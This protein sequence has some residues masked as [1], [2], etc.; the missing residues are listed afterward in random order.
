ML[1]HQTVAETV[2]DQLAEWGLDAVFGV[3]GDA[4]I[5]LLDA[6]GAQDRVRFYPARREDAAAFMASAYGKL[7]GR[8]GVCI[9]TSGPGAANLIN[10][11]AD[12]AQDRIPLLVITGQVESWY[13]GTNYK[14]Y[15]D[16]LGLYRPF[17]TYTT[18][19]ANPQ[20]TVEV[21][22]H[23]IKAAVTRRMVSHVSIPKDLFAMAAPAAI[24]PPEP[25]LLTHPISP[26]EVIDGVL[27]ILNQARQPVILAG[28]GTKGY[29]AEL[30]A[31]AEQW[32]AGI[33]HTMPA[34]GVVPYAHPLAL[35][36]LGLAG[37][38]PAANAVARADLCLV[39][40]ATW[41]PPDHAPR[42]L[43]VV[44]IDVDPANIGVQT[45]VHYGIVG[46]VGRILPILTAQIADNPRTDWR[47]TIETLRR[48]WQE[49]MAGETG[50]DRGPIS[51]QFLVRTLQ[52]AVDPYAVIALDVGD[53]FVWFAR[54]YEARY[55]DVLI[56]GRWRS[57]GFGLPA[58]I[59]ARLRHPERQ[60][61][62]FT[63]DGGFGMV[64]AELATVV[65][66]YLPITIVVVN[67]QVLAMELN[68]M[69]VGNYRPV[70]VNLHNPNFADFARSV[71]CLGWRVEHPADLAPALREALSANQP[72]LV[73]VLTANVVAPGTKV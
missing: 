9:A 53:H 50:C 40:G 38:D 13:I 2:V 33:V 26:P 18:M 52:D 61:V 24:R 67:N 23:A 62:V 17:T 21:L 51:P 63:G 41:W 3:A 11:V 59:T 60:V 4:I 72:A 29:T 28:R 32:G 12:A 56:S 54:V 69:V 48:E 43:P 14:Q 64:M 34:T 27:P 45:P 7:T 31:F 22:T 30:T 71:G 36:S 49:R 66:L 47:H 1:K 55:E 46:D 57:M 16:H 8:P 44:Q 15:F 20:S 25:Y 5:P 19:L 39:A 68:R 10:G 37:K 42:S 58:A 73:D 6:L 35:G 70:G 65:Q